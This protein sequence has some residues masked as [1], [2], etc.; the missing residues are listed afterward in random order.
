MCRCYFTACQS[1]RFRGSLTRALP[2]DETAMIHRCEYVLGGG[3]GEE[4]KYAIFFSELHGG[5]G[6]SEQG[7]LRA[8]PLKFALM[9]ILRCQGVANI[10]PL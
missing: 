2:R 10:A 5:G 1:H 4:K 7:V 9:K 3:G 8:G 6:G